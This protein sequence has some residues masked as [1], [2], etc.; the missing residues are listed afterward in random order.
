MSK[1]DPNFNLQYD[2]AF[3]E[4]GWKDGMDNNLLKLGSIVQLGVLSDD[5]VDPPASP[6]EGDRYIIPAGAT[7]DWSGQDGDVAIYV[8]GQWV[9]YTPNNGWL[10]LVGNRLVGYNDGWFDPLL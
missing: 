9:F 4:S 1:F 8:D 10:A 6:S 2:W 5:T 3:R 7:G